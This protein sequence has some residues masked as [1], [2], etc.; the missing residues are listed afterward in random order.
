MNVSVQVHVSVNDV[1][2]HVSVNDVRVHRVNGVSV[3]RAR[4]P[5]VTPGAK[6]PLGGRKPGPTPQDPPIGP[7]R[8]S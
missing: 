7:N 6:P 4:V 5:S 3:P 1:R 8:T 2:V